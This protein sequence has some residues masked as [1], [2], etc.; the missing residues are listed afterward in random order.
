M[1]Q[2]RQVGWDVPVVISGSALT[3]QL[4]ELLGDEVNG[5]Y[6]N[7]AF[8]PSDDDPVTSELQKN[9][10]RKQRCRRLFTV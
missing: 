2:I 6:S 1:K 5:I 7:I 3:D 8:V 10:Q 4:V 9:L